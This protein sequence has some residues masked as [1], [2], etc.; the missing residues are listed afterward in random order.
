MKK[1]IFSTMAITIFAFVMTS[2]QLK[3]PQSKDET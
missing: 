1:Q 3:K 2:C